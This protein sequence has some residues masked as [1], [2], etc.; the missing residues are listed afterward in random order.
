MQEQRKIKQEVLSAN[1]SSIPKPEE[2]GHSGEP[3]SLLD[4]H[5]LNEV[6][7]ALQEMK[8]ECEKSSKSEKEVISELPLEDVVRESQASTT[9]R[10]DPAPDAGEVVAASTAPT[11]EGQGDG[12]LTLDTRRL[13]QDFDEL[14]LESTL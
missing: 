8:D 5:A 6:I 14:C 4:L 12:L 2:S 1:S 13:L 9:P 3:T 10:L 11:L 7:E